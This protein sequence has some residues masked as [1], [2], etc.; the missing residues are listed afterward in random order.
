MRERRHIKIYLLWCNM[1]DERYILNISHCV[2]C[3]NGR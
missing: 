1:E 3:K 2:I